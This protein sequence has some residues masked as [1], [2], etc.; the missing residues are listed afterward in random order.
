MI[1]KN[2][3]RNEIRKN[4]DLKPKGLV[5]NGMKIISVVPQGIEPRS[6]VPETCILS[7]VLR[8]QHV[9]F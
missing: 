9:A 7:V 5:I 8:D 4:V 2:I 1:I 6:Q 3:S